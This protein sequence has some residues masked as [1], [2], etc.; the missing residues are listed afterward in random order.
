MVAR[1]SAPHDWRKDRQENEARGQGG[2]EVED[3]QVEKY[4]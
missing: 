3:E 2:R 4:F 1:G